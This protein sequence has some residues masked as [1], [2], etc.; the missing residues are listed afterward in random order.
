MI[1]GDWHRRSIEDPYAILWLDDASR[2]ILSAGEFDKATTEYS[3][4]TLKEAQKKVEE[5]NLKNI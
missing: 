1:H 4:Q 5:Y 2:F 3:I